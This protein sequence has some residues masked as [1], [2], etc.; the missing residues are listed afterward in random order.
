M[1]YI[2]SGKT[3]RA[4]L[5][6]HGGRAPRWLFTRMVELSRQ[7]VELFLAEISPDALLE[8]LSDPYWFQALGCVLGF[9]WHSSG[10]TTTV[11]GAIKQALADLGR[12]SGIYAAGGKGRVSRKTPSEIENACEGIGLDAAP[13][14]YASRMSAKVD[15]AGVQDGFNLYHHAFFFTRSGDWCVIQQG[16]NPTLRRARR[17]HW[18]GERVSSFTCEPHTAVCCDVRAP[19]LN[20][21]SAD[22]GQVR[23]VSC[24]V[25]A[26]PPE[27]SFSLLLKASHAL[28]SFS[29]PAR[30]HLKPTD[31][32]PDRMKKVLLQTYA[33]EPR[34]YEQLLS[35]RGVGPRSLRA[36]ALVSEVVFGHVPSY[37]DPARFAF[38]HGGKD[39]H[40]Y[41]V[42]MRTY[43]RTVDVVRKAIRAAKMGN[44]EKVDALRRLSCFFDLG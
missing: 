12:D 11:C 6:L 9:D 17:Y 30:H 22:S 18:L 10:L 24:E 7:I 31:I 34:T 39:G 13:L 40:P 2:P 4:D 27:K 23:S 29:M 3:G 8:R 37:T 36:L 25:A 42:H 16:M 26:A 14:V 5:P 1:K 41:P 32:N 15:N 44:R 19:T 35:I 21:V 33:N 43:D 20:L 38:A 28:S